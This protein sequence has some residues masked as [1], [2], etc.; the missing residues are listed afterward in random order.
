MASQIKREHVFGNFK[1]SRT[2]GPQKPHK[3]SEKYKDRL[4]M[5]E[6]HLALIRKMPCAICLRVPCGECHHIK[7]QTGERGMGQKST[8]KWGTPLCHG[9]HM[10]VEGVGTRNEISWFKSNGVLDAHL[11][12]RDLWKATGNLPQMVKI[13]LAH[14]GHK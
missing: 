6:A 14:R 8:D 3:N 12:A 9:H 10:E 7:A 1:K 13:L 5:S 2:E 4:G 11:L